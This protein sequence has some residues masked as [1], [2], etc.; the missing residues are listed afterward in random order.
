M[1]FID[2]RAIGEREPMAGFRGRFFHSE[3]MTFAYWDIQE[4]AL[5]PEHSHPHEQVVNM[6]AGSF[7]LTIEG[8]TQVLEPGSVAI[9]HANEKHAGK[10]LTGCRILD[11]FSPVREDYR[12]ES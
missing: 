2:L 7:E 1:Q 10:A 11:V 4:G 3:Y 5:L 8:K 6:I 12:F 9:I